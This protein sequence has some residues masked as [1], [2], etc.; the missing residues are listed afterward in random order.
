MHICGVHHGNNSKKYSRASSTVR[1]WRLT[2]RY[3]T[4]RKPSQLES[5]QVT[6]FSIFQKTTQTWLFVSFWHAV[7]HRYDVATFGYSPLIL[8]LCVQTDTKYGETIYITHHND[9]HCIG[10]AYTRCEYDTLSTMNDH[11]GHRTCKQTWPLLEGLGQWQANDWRYADADCV[12]LWVQ[13][14]F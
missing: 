5:V 12:R 1:W 6:V 11:K 7:K 3:T 13:S 10:K 9:A 4:F 14:H 8:Q 2:S